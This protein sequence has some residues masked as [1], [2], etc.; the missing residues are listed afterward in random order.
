M[1]NNTSEQEI[2]HIELFLEVMNQIHNIFK[3]IELQDSLPMTNEERDRLEREW[4][5]YCDYNYIL[6]G[7]YIEGFNIGMGFIE[8]NEPIP[9][10]ITDKGNAIYE[11]LKRPATH[12]MTREE[13]N[14]FADKWLA[15]TPFTHTQ[16]GAFKHGHKTGKLERLRTNELKGKL[17]TARNLKGMGLSLENISQAT[18]LSIEEIEKL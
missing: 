17:E 4:L 5:N 10:E 9:Q 12:P 1:T 8:P 15:R 16:I 7:A 6:S 14:Q 3:G 2:N 11:S 18:G 13:R